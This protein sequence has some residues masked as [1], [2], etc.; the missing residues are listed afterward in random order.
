MMRRDTRNHSLISPLGLDHAAVSDSASPRMRCTLSQQRQ[1]SESR[2]IYNYSTLKAYKLFHFIYIYMYFYIQTLAPNIF[3][4]HDC[5]SSCKKKISV[6]KKYL[7]MFPTSNIVLI[8]Y[9]NK[10]QT[11][12]DIHVV[13]YLD[14]L[15]SLNAHPF[16]KG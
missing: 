1:A 2:Y 11:L 14:A 5:I 8:S 12:F 3:T 9:V 16:F 10:N 4:L 13:L 7:K 15:V 6:L